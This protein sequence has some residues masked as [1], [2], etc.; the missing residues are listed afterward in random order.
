M[1]KRLL[2]ATAAG[3]LMMSTALAQQ[4]PAPSPTPPAAS[5]PAASPATPKMDDKATK[6]DSAAM[7]DGK[8]IAAQSSDVWAWSKFKGTDVIGTNNEKIGD[9]DD[10]LFDKQGKVVGLV[11]GVGGFLGIG[12]KNVAI[13]MAAFEVVSGDAARAATRDTGTTGTAANRP[14]TTGSADPDDFKLKVSWTKEQLKDAPAF[15]YHKASARTTGS[16]PG[17]APRPA[18]STT[19]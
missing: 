1:L 6:A 9:V 18:G 15:E 11:V 16:A 7:K 13:D 5:P 10:V 12:Q 17:T 2:I 14:A 3:G 8:F 4:A 19:R